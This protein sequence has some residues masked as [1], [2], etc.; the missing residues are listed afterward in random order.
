MEFADVD[1]MWVKL[2]FGR[3]VCVMLTKTDGSTYEL[4][5]RPMYRWLDAW[6]RRSVLMS[7]LADRSSSRPTS[8]VSKRVTDDSAQAAFRWFT[9]PT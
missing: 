8:Q 9:P 6:L 7:P 2:K 3:A 5:G 1:S 4:R